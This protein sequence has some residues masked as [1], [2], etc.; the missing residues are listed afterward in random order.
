MAM[1]NLKCT[2]VW[3][4]S[5]LKIQNIIIGILGMLLENFEIQFLELN[6]AL[7]LAKKIIW[8]VIVRHSLLVPLRI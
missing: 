4:W 7:N 5:I 8:L 1:Q 6:L 3:S 2:Q